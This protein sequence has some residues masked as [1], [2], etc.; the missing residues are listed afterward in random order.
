MALDVITADI[1]DGTHHGFFTRKG[2][3]S[4]GIYAGLNCGRGSNDVPDHVEANRA[5][6][7]Q[8]MGVTAANLASVHQYHSADVI[9]VD[10]PLGTPPKADAMVT[11]TKGCALGILTADCQPVLFADHKA[12]VVGAAH[13]GW[14]GAKAG[15]LQATVDAMVSLGADPTNIVAAIGPCIHQD[16]YEVGP[17]FI[18]AVTH[19]DPTALTFFKQGDGDRMRFDLPG[20]GLLAL[21][22]AGVTRAVALDHCTYADPDRFFSYRRTCHE[23]A[24]DYGRLIACI[25]L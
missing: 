1:L 5:L 14:K 6:V 20:Y 7:A 4:D 3:V 2:G 8:H 24:A 25:V 18:E 22:R 21:E 11:K 9:V 10:G 15:V 16:N 19:D 13:A 12:G 17:D 23:K